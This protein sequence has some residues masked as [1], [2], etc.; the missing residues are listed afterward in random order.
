MGST[1]RSLVAPCSTSSSSLSA[2]IND[3]SVN[4]I[5][6]R[7]GF[8]GTAGSA[9][10]AAAA[11]VGKPD[12]A[13]GADYSG[14]VLVLGGTGFVGSEVCKQLKALG[15]DVVA[16]SRDGRDGT[17]ALDFS[18]SSVDATKTVEGMAKGCTAVISCVGSIGT[19]NDKL[20]NSGTVLSS[21]GAKAAGVKRFVYISVAPE[22]R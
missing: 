8:M 15:V 3:D 17:L 4:F 19:S 6:S 21:I 18:D 20:V 16:T 12:L 9:L 2:Q 11:C 7:R 10:I 13:I 22:V 1:S 14:K 5:S